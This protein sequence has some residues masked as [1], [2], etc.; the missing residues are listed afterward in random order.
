MATAKNNPKPA[1]DAK[2]LVAQLPRVVNT[3]VADNKLTNDA[4]N[5]YDDVDVEALQT[6]AI[7]AHNQSGKLKRK[8]SHLQIANIL[9]RYKKGLLLGD[10]NP[11]K[12]YTESKLNVTCLKAIARVVYDIPEKDEEGKKISLPRA[13]E[14]VIRQ[15]ANVIYYAITNRA[16]LTW[17]AELGSLMVPAWLVITDDTTNE[18]IESDP[19]LRASGA[20]S[21]PVPL[22]GKASRTL[23]TV[24]TQCP[25]PS[26]AKKGANDRTKQQKVEDAVKATFDK[27]GLAKSLSALVEKL[28]LV[29]G[30]EKYSDDI[31][32]HVAILVEHV[33]LR[34]GD[35]ALAKAADSLTKK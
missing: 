3:V 11:E 24:R 27:Y 6:E 33:R 12:L 30:K 26:R 29:K 35:D 20:F 21:K 16:P 34:N 9:A 1:D 28:S 13:Y 4:F 19:T 31:V 15:V 25:D 32:E 2:A 7:N 10:A 14:A 17:N 5:I 18:L 8:E 23:E 22:D